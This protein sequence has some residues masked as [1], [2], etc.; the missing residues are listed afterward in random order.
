MSQFTL[1]TLPPSPNNVKVRLALKLKGL[2]YDAKEFA[3]DDREEVIAK[4]G[5]PLTPV[6]LDGDTVV[7]DS[8]GILRYLDANWPEPRLFSESREGQ[9]AIQAWERFAVSEVGASLG[10]LIGSFLSGTDD[11]ALNASVQSAFDELPKKVEEALTDAPY[12]GGGSP[13]A[14]DIT[15]APFFHF[16]AADP[17]EFPEGSPGR[18]AAERCHLGEQFPRTRAWVGR[19]MAI[20]TAQPGERAAVASA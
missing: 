6:L 7:Y 16:A 15:V 9:Q 12:L 4:S 13:N 11:P 18:F 3:F 8:F 17:N 14:A 19:V 10:P 5:Q 2:S 20:D 1:L